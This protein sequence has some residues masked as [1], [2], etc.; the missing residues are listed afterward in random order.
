MAI[1]YEYLPPY[2]PTEM[3]QNCNGGNGYSYPISCCVANAISC[4]KAIMDYKSFGVKRNYSTMWIYA[5]RKTK[6]YEDEFMYFEWALDEMRIY[7]APYYYRLP[8]IWFYKKSNEPVGYPV[9]PQKAS[10]QIFNDNYS[11]LYAEAQNN[12]I[13]TW[14]SLGIDTSNTNTIKQAILDNGC[15]VIRMLRSETIANIDSNYI[16][17]EPITRINNNSENIGLITETKIERHNVDSPCSGGGVYQLAGVSGGGAEGA[18]AHALV[19]YGW[20]KINGVDYWICRNGWGN[21]N[22]GSSSW[23]NDGDC[24]VKIGHRELTHCFELINSTTNPSR[25]FE[26]DTPKI[27]D[28][29]FLLTANEW[30]KIIQK[31]NKIYF[32]RGYSTCYKYYYEYLDNI[33]YTVSKG[34]KFTANNFKDVVNCLTYWTLYPKAGDKITALLL[35]QLMDKIND[36]LEYT[37]K[38]TN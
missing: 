30:N 15:V 8:L 23:G 36:D 3:S 24:Y 9:S 34:D 26:Y 35:N 16:V 11:S 20:K 28:E 32:L 7:G 38:E 2:K 18:V 25:M 4:A 1:P 12:T 31:C 27:K 37:I 22:G 29:P 13:S 14:Y 33:T 5:N 19:A 21:M 17:P 6:P 10:S